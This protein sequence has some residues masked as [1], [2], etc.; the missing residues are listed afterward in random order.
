MKYKEF[1]NTG[2]K[3]SAISLGSW[4][5]G[6]AGWGEIDEEQSKEA[7]LMMLERG[8]NV[9]DTAPVYGFVN[10]GKPDFGF[11]YAEEFLG[12]I[13][14]KRRKEVFLVTKCG[15]NYDRKKGPASMYKSMTGEEIVSGCEESLRRLRTD[16]ID[17]LFVHW[18]DHKTP[19]EEVADA[20]ER[21]IRSG[22]IRY[23]GLSNFS[24]EDMCRMDDMLHVGAVQL[25]YS[26]V[27]RKSEP[28]LLEA[29]ERGIGTMTYA[30]LG[31]GILSGAY[32]SMPKL[33]K[34]DTRASFYHFF[35]EPLFGKIQ[36]LLQVMDEI[37]ARHQAAPAQV[38]IRWSVEKA[39]VDN[40][41]LGVSKPGHAA[42]NCD[43]FL[44]E[45]SDEEMR[46]LD[47]AVETYLGEDF[48]GKEREI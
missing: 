34:N 18:P 38:A 35:E 27:D 13:L 24:K 30:S 10:P 6:G 17:L 48:M 36:K 14:E 12:R 44:W 25:P 8:V 1:G 33:D 5:I 42:A 19:L 20:M 16:Y 43:A 23:Y 2:K 3:L 45:M 4:G 29:W 40:A 15:L 41:I 11:G 7:V 26:M 47:E 31:A 32:R 39:F 9:V 28:L 22:K 21:L 46:I 37:A